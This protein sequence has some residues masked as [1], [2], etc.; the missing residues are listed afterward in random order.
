MCITSS[1][2]QRI[3]FKAAVRFFFFESVVSFLVLFCCL[4]FSKVEDGDEL[5]DECSCKC[6]LIFLLLL[7]ACVFFLHNSMYVSRRRLEYYCCFGWCS[8]LAQRHHLDHHHEPQ[9]QHQ[10]HRIVVNTTAAHNFYGTLH[11]LLCSNMVLC[12]TDTKIEVE[13]HIICYSYYA[14]CMLHAWSKQVKLLF[15]VKMERPFLS[16]LDIT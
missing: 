13:T 14:V 10:P 9:Q 4:L 7:Q 11:V 16:L 5:Y 1:L 6:V 15:A 12:T 3:K 2:T 8:V